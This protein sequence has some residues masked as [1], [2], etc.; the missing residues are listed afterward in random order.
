MPSLIQRLFTVR[1]GELTAALLASA[2]FFCV[3]SC[4]YILKPIREQMGIA[5]G[6][7]KLSWL[8]TGTFVAMLVAQPIYALLVM[9]STRRRLIAVSYRFF[10]ANLLAFFAL[11]HFAPAWHPFAVA[12]SFYVWVSVFNLFVVSVFWS[13]M[14]DVFTLEQGKRLF[15]FISVGGT[16]GAIF[17]AR[18]TKGLVESVGPTNLLLFS[19]LF[20]EA[21]VQLMHA[22]A[23]RFDISTV[24]DAQPGERAESSSTAAV[25]AR[26]MRIEDRERGGVFNGIALVLGSRYLQGICLFML[27]YALISTFLYYEVSHVIEATIQ[28]RSARTA[29]FADIDFKVNAIALVVQVFL[30]GRVVKRIGIGWTI[31]LLPLISIAFLLA[32]GSTPSLAVVVVAQIAFRGAYF[33][34]AKPAREMLFTVVGREAKYKSKNFID[35]FVHRGGDVVGGWI[36]RGLQGGLNMSLGQVAYV[37]AGFAVAWAIVS[38]WLGKQEQRFERE[39]PRAAND[40]SSSTAT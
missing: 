15:G 19:M 31:M 33:A 40:E 18:L 8:Y 29:L 20:L 26:A 16:L 3:L 14:A 24:G 12:A 7:D 25:P 1:K 23:R 4:Y 38:R 22:V 30:T 27:G 10:A 28:D 11:L 36:F 34:T 5:H 21:A 13:F 35:T 39:T 9:R 17:G 2:Y 6:V 37:G 32:V